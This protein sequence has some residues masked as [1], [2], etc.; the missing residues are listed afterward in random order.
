MLHA[1]VPLIG[2]LGIT[3]PIALWKWRTGEASVLH[4]PFMMEAEMRA[5]AGVGVEHGT[6]AKSPGNGWT[7]SRGSLLM[8]AMIW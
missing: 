7:G 1:A 3:R 4:F 5:H 2:N 8:I 6:I